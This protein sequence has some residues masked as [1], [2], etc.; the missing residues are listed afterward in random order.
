MN[1]III[2]RTQLSLKEYSGQRVVTFR[3][4]DTV[5]QRPDGTASRNFRQYKEHFVENEDFYSLNQPDEIRRLGITRPQGGT[6]AD[7]ILITESGYLMLVKSFTDGLSWQVQRQLVKT[8]FRHHETDLSSLSPELREMIHIETEQKR[9][10]KAIKYVS[11]RVDNMSEI[12]SLNKDTWRKDAHRLVV[13]IAQKM[14]GNEF[15]QDVHDKLYEFVDQR[16][17]ANLTRR[18]ENQKMR[19]LAAGGSKSK[20]DKLNRIDVI[21]ADKRLTEIYII[22]LKEMCIQYGVDSSDIEKTA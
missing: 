2:G 5:H 22:V 21:A 20:T 19:M 7:V 16:A 6:P 3:D 18:L 11:N 14:G 15:I 8:Y 13:K 1:N 9:Q 10:A 4:I 12:I 17:G